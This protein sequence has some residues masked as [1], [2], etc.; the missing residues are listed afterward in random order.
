M[1]II[2]GANNRMRKTSQVFLIACSG[3]KK[4]L[5]KGAP[6]PEVRARADGNAFPFID[7]KR[8]ELISYYSTLSQDNARSVYVAPRGSSENKNGKIEKTRLKNTSLKLFPTMPAIERYTGTVYEI[9]RQTLCGKPDF[10]A[11]NE[12]LIIS[13]L[14]GILNTNDMIPDYELMMGDKSPKGI[15]LFKW[16]HDVFTKKNLSAKLKDVYPDL[17]NIYF[18]MSDTTGYVAGVRSLGESYR[19]YLV[20]VPDGNLRRSPEVWGKSLKKCLDESASD[21]AQVA[22]IVEGEGC[23][24]IPYDRS[25]YRR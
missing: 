3:R 4:S 1:K 23:S 19:T 20:H 13:S 14:F 11:Q 17:Q 2:I 16:W 22:R 8:M 24:L 21:P 5:G 25:R 12:V 7:D 15:A 9:L 18:F 6:W 10:D